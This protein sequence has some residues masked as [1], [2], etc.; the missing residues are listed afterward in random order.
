MAPFNG[1]GLTATKLWNHYCELSNLMGLNLVP[2]TTNLVH[3]NH[4]VIATFQHISF[5]R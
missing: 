5:N 2:Q 4:K 1:L 3:P